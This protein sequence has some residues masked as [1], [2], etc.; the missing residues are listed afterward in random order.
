MP[1][2]D[3]IDLQNSRKSYAYGNVY[4]LFAPADM[5]LPFQIMVPHTDGGSG[6]GGWRVYNRDGALQADLAGDYAA[7]PLQILRYPEYGYDIVVFPATVQMRT[8]LEPGI[9]YMEMDVDGKTYYSDMFT[10]AD[11]NPA[12]LKMEWWDDED[13]VFDAGRVAYAAGY[14]NRLYFCTEIGK[15]GY[16]Y[17]EEG[18]DRD[19]YFFPE[20]RLTWK[21]YKFNILAPEYLCDVLRLAQLADHVHVTD[22]YGRKYKC[23]TLQAEADWQT[24]GDLAAVDVE[25]TTDTVVK[26]IGRGY[27]ASDIGGDFN[28]DFNADFYNP[29]GSE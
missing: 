24:Q 25:F 11:G 5:L 15:P 12:M 10:A 8:P 19:G 4:P 2:Y 7:L 20:K 13:M 23:D 16:E 3:S 1:W 28:A 17:E 27:V 26:K 29:G 22:K 18:E 6:I 14:R 21:I 9:H